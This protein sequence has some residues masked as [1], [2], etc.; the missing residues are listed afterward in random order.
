M[1]DWEENSSEWNDEPCLLRQEMQ[2]Q[3]LDVKELYN[4]VSAEVFRFDG[5]LKSE[6]YQRLLSEKRRH[7]SD[8]NSLTTHINELKKLDGPK[9]QRDILDEEYHE[10]QKI[11]DKF[12]NDN[13]KPVPE[14]Q[15]EERAQEYMNELV[16]ENK[17]ED[18][19]SIDNLLDEL[20]L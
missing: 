5:D 4:R 17:T 20:G 15:E 2:E 7:V 6:K 3:R 9:D 18:S 1:S 11:I 19:K 16:E 12:R 8:I 13:D 14:D 10:T